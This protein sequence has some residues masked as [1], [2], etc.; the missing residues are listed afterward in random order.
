MIFFEGLKGTLGLIS[1]TAALGLGYYMNM[2]NT[3]A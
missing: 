1:M 2:N 3:G